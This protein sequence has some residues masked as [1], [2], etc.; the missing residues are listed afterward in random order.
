MKFTSQGA[1][2]GPCKQKGRLARL[3]P[4]ELIKDLFQEPSVPAASPSLQSASPSSCSN[5]LQLV[6]GAHWGRK[7]AACFNKWYL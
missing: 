5:D 3:L 4:G 1:T 2:K 7:A 6:E